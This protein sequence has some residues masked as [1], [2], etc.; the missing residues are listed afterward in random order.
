MKFRHSGDLGDCI[1]ALPILKAIPG[2]H[3]L[4][5]VDRPGITRPLTPRMGLL[6]PLFE[7]Q[8]Y[9]EQ[10]IAS[11]DNPDVDIVPFRRFHS[12]ITTLVDAQLNEVNSYSAVPVK[13]D[14]TVPWLDVEPDESM[15]GKIIIAR[16]PRYNNNFFPWRQIVNHY[17]DRLLFVGIDQEYANFCFVN[18]NVKKIE[19]TDYL[20]LARLI[21]GADLF[22]GN[23]SSPMAVAIG[24][25]VPFIQEAC[26]EQP[27]CIFKRSNAQYV[28]DGECTLPDVSGS[29]ELKIT[30]LYKPTFSGNRNTVPPGYWQ[31]PGLPSGNHFTV[32]SGLVAKK[33]NIPKQEA[34]DA[35]YEHN[36]NRVPD[37]FTGH[38]N[39]PLY[40]FN[41]AY[42]NAFNT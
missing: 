37:F 13:V 11:E 20:H 39:N 27:D 26:L 36:L 18:G 41:R 31:F 7:A 2:Q 1:Y 24:L 17:G 15:K 33:L 34:E 25:G 30:K 19:I 3:S 22:I 8:D 16:S 12:S 4:L 23:Q 29:G 14:V 6:K 9:I 40:L 5:F 32:Q 21:K 38:I 35:L 42:I 28:G 10:V